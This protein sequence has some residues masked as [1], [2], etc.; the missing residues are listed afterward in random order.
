MLP[1][2]LYVYCISTTLRSNLR[3]NDPGEFAKGFGGPW[4]EMGYPIY[5]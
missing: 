2:L 4:A 5:G 3:Y 1:L